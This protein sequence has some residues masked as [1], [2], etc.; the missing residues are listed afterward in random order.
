MLKIVIV[1]LLMLGSIFWG[2]FP[3][4]EGSPHN[5]IASYLGYENEI[6]YSVYILIGTIFYVMAAFL[7]QQTSIE[8][9]WK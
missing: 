1:S 2:L 8:Y 6:H 9:F 5:L 3:A 7:S 4:S